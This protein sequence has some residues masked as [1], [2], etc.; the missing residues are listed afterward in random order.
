[1]DR[2]D[3]G[4][5]HAIQWTEKIKHK[6]RPYNGEKRQSTNTGHTMNK[7]DKGQAQAIQYTKNTKEKHRS[8]N[9]QKR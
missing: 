4:Q 7:K 1:M 8:Y 5:T 9:V 6:H 3:K 2:K